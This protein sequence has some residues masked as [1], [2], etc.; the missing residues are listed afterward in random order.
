MLKPGD[1]MLSADAVA[2]GRSPS[3]MGRISRSDSMIPGNCGPAGGP[4]VKITGAISSG[5]I[6]F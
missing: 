4:G 5:I 6:P 2:P 3:A 1:R